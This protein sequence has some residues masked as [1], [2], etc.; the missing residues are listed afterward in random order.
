MQIGFVLY[1]QVVPFFRQNRVSFFPSSLSLG[2][3]SNFMQLTTDPVI[4]IA[5][6]DWSG[7]NNFHI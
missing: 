4:V 7:L 3:S 2:R 6:L 5:A 1:I